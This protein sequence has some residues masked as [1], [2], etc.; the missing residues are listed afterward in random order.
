MMVVGIKPTNYIKFLIVQI[1]LNLSSV[2][3]SLIL[4]PKV[5]LRVM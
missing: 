2:Q 1:R 4:P 3:V 5:H